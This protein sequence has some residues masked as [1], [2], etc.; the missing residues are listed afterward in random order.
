MSAP[1]LLEAVAA[2]IRARHYSSRT[3]EAYLHW[4]RRLVR[5]TG[6]HPRELGPTEVGGFLSHLAVRERVAAATQNQALAALLFLYR[7]VLGTP[8]PWLDELVRAQVRQHLPVVLS[9]DEVA[10]VLA[11]MQGT[12]R[13]VASLLYG[14]GLRLLE[15]LHLRIKDV[16]LTRGTITVRAGKGDK[17]RQTLLPKPLLAS[18]RTQRRSVEIQHQNDLRGGAGYVEL[19]QSLEIGRAHV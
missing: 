4:V 5:H 14:S 11:V 12:P 13:L 3:E 8:L 2:A 7:H 6:R 17:D 15:A 10:A 19:P 18:L 1:R 16:D 9:R